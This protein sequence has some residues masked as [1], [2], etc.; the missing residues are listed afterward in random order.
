MNSSEIRE[1]FLKYFEANNHK[2]L[3]E[4]IEGKTFSP[5]IKYNNKFNPLLRTKTHKQ[6]RVFKDGTLYNDPINK[7]HGEFKILLNSVWVTDKS[8]GLNWLI[9]EI[10]LDL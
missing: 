10:N 5:S 1:K 8:Y 3:K 7:K 2:R 6:F 9:K 4:L